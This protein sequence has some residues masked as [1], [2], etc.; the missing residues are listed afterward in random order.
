MA[1]QMEQVVLEQETAEQEVYVG[2]RP[3][4]RSQRGLFFGRDREVSELLS[5]VISSRAVLFYAPS[6]A[7]KTSLINAGLHPYLEQESF[8]VLPSARVRGLLPK[9][10]D[11]AQVANIYMFNALL[12]LAGEESAP[13]ELVDRTLVEFLSAH[14]HQLDEL[15][16]PSPRILIFDQFEELLNSY[17]ERWQE[18]DGFFQQIHTALQAD[19]LLRVLFAIR[20]DFLA[21]IESYLRLL[22]PF[23]LTRFRLPLLGPEGALA[24]V[25]GPLR[26]TGRR[27]KEGVAETLVE[28]LL[29]EH[30]ETD[31]G[32]PLEV[33]GE[34]VEPVQLQVVCLNLWVKLPA[35]VQ[36]ISRGDVS[37]YGDVDQAL[38]EFYDT[39]IEGARDN[40]AA[41][42]LY[43]R[44]WFEKQLITPAGTRGIVFRGVRFTEG[45][46]N[47][48]VDFLV[49]RHLIRGEWRAGSRWYELTHDRF[50]KP[51]QRA[52]ERWRARRRERRFRWSLAVGIPVLLALIL[53]AAINAY[54]AT[55]GTPS[56]SAATVTAAAE[57]QSTAQV[58]AEVAQGEAQVAREDLAL[59][60]SRQLAA[61][62]LLVDNRDLAL[63]L[64]IEA[65]RQADTDEARKSLHKILSSKGVID[66]KFLREFNPEVISPRIIERLEGHANWVLSVAFS[67]D[68]KTLASGSADTTIRL[69][70]AHSG[71]PIGEPLA[72]HTSSVQSV[73]FSPDGT[74]IASA[75]PDTQ[76]LLWD[77][78]TGERLGAPFL[79]HVG[80]VT[81]VAFS[82]DGKR[83][84]SSGDD[85]TIRIWDVA[86]RELLNVEGPRV[87]TW[88]LAWS[89][90]GSL[91]ASGGVDSTVRIWDAETLSEVRVLRGHQGLVRSVAW[92]PD[93][94]FLASGSVVGEEGNAWGE[95]FLRDA[96]SGELIARPLRENSQPVRTVAFNPSGTI[97]AV[98]RDDGTIGLWDTRSES[99]L[100]DPLTGHDNRVYSLAFS[101]DGRYMAS[102][103]I[104]QTVVLWDL[105][106]PTRSIAFSPGG[107]FMAVSEGAVINIWDPA[108]N[109]S[110]VGILSG[111][112]DDVLALAFNPDGS[113]LASAGRDATIRLWDTSSWEAFGPP[114]TGHSDDVLTLDF[115]RP[116]GSTL[117]SGGQDGKVLLWDV[118]SGKNFDEFLYK[119]NTP[120]L[121]VRFI[122]E[123]PPALRIAGADGNL[124]T[125][126]LET[127]EE[128]RE[129][130]PATRG[131]AITSFVISADGLRAAFYQEAGGA[132]VQDD[133]R[134]HGIEISFYDQSFDPGVNPDDIDFIILWP[135]NGLQIDS[136]FEGYLEPAQ[137]V[138]IRGATHLYQP[139]Q[140]WQEQA[141][142]FLSI[143]KDKIFH[144]F[145]LDVEFKP[146]EDSTKFASDIQQWLEYVQENVNQK[147]LLQA[148]VVF[149][150]TWLAPFSDDWVKDWPLLIT[151]YPF[152]PDRNG[153]P[154]LPA[155]VTDWK[156]WEYTENGVGA[157]YGVGPDGVVLDV[158]NGTAQEMWEWLDI[159]AF[160]IYDQPSGKLIRPSREILVTGPNDIAFSPDDSYLAAGGGRTVSL[161]SSGSGEELSALTT[162]GR[163]IASLGFQPD[164]RMLAVG[165]DDGRV[166]LWDLALLYGGTD[167]ESTLEV[168]CKLANRNFTQEEWD[169][170][171]GTEPY[172]STCPNLP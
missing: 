56:V 39:S 145:T 82:P 57:A 90:D 2:P 33:V 3:F 77:A 55:T 36:E 89:P 44:G 29:K 150:N 108:D 7:G 68:G 73:A 27:F 112:T 120:V 164:G 137:S 139:D 119:E 128:I 18:R 162:G 25:T 147:V 31:Q 114:L 38:Q 17:P 132:I 43:L 171:L 70:D 152:E 11:Q 149:Y 60:R 49:N 71:Q 142:L 87:S 51:I 62:A 118:A 104:D 165:T 74:L 81:S 144:F 97:L 157:E 121:E 134:A 158:Y 16:F 95:V 125:L 151:Y 124:I 23:Q 110:P 54:Q 129:V 167:T 72:G 116:D 19:P 143:V 122:E 111:H 26:G 58:K 8:E 42:E 28:E 107:E 41:N 166:F 21:P 5:L 64:A 102:G 140:P 53:F 94:Q 154:L 59:S 168:A 65:N 12:S 15:G 106:A 96:V 40:Q 84:A 123:V 32:K 131:V 127:H 10:I 75:S 155:G 101:P 172:D 130:L 146:S 136:K 86:T 113:L 100:V 91:L 109:T 135:T 48:V 50:I 98:G 88:S 79:G 99:T 133:Q 153:S 141:D 22:K 76:I 6:G 4:E 83:L 126:N 148:S 61:Q 47:H 20:E 80:I 156:I 45:L 138:P 66:G 13:G 93:G 159:S 52:N 14:P 46:P 161:M 30:W 163:T 69:W 85:G 35:E 63:L 103:S 37:K 170:Y 115:T 67:P 1:D 117:A 78:S 160:S 92:S 34:Y 105:F 169:R 24:A 9:G